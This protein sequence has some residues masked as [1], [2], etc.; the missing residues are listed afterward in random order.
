MSIGNFMS[1]PNIIFYGLCNVL[2]VETVARYP[3]IIDCKYLSHSVCCE[4]YALKHFK[5]VLLNCSHVALH[6][7]LYPDVVL[8]RILNNLLNL[9]TTL[10]KKFRAS[11]TY[12]LFCSS[13]STKL[14]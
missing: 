12:Q 5:I 1:L 10:D 4:Q 14:S 8:L 7:G 2:D 11:I 3:Y 9:D 13:M 6:C